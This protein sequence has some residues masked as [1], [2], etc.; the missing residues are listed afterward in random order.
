MLGIIRK[1]I[2]EMRARH[3]NKTRQSFLDLLQLHESD[4]AHSEFYHRDTNF[5]YHTLDPKTPLELPFWSG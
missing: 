2:T 1:K 5:V 4:F 3:K